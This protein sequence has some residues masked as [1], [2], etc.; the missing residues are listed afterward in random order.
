MA[1]LHVIMASPI[2]HKWSGDLAQLLHP[3][4]ILQDYPYTEEKHHNVWMHDTPHLE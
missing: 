4:H 3:N 2:R 1:L